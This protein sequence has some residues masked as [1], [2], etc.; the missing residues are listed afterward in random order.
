MAPEFEGKTPDFVNSGLYDGLFVMKDE[1][2]GS[3]WNHVTGEAMYGPSA[4]QRMGVGN[5][6]QMTVKVALEREPQMLVAISDRPFNKAGHTARYTN[7]DAEMMDI[8]TLTLGKEDDRRPRMEVGLGIWLGDQRRYY[9][10]D[11]LRERGNF[12]IDNFAGRPTLV[13]LDPI[14]ST[15]QAIYVAAS[16]VSFEGS[17]VILD[18]GRKIISGRLFD[19]N[20]AELNAERPQQ[21]FTRW[22]GFALTFPEP[23]IFE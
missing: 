8:F 22:Y 12:V 3:L 15:P 6:L 7:P 20:G 14:T 5:L 11:L 1:A 2:T 16:S 10:M 4:G 21:M 13:Y 17:D 23:D 18:Q 19:Q 9:P